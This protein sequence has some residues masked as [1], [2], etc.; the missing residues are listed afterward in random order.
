MIA[1]AV[2]ATEEKLRFINDK[3][4]RL[5]DD[6]VLL[7][8]AFLWTLSSV[9]TYGAESDFAKLCRLAKVSMIPFVKMGKYMGAENEVLYHLSNPQDY[10]DEEI[11]RLAK[12]KQ[13]QYAQKISLFLDSSSKLIKAI[14]EDRIA[15][16]ILYSEETYYSESYFK[17]VGDSLL[18]EDLQKIIDYLTIAREEGAEFAYFF[19]D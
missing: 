6:S 10:T 7:N 8:D 11:E 4:E 14:S 12:K 3:Y 9:D 16:Q 1:I 19:I 15:E 2:E 13:K 5:F 18:V 17:G